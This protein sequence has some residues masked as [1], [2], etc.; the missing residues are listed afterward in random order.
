[1]ENQV[2]LAQV[3]VADKSNEISAIPKILDLLSLK[4]TTITVDA[5]GCQTD[6]ASKIID[7]G[8][9]CALSL[10]ANQQIIH[11]EVSEFFDDEREGKF[12][13]LSHDTWEITEKGPGRIEER[14]YLHG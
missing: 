11:E 8:A 12:K 9:D 10:K 4:G 14:F 3:K 5:M 2:V 7:K 13:A 6:I 1:M